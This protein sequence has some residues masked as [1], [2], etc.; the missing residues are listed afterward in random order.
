M[1]QMK[2]VN[3]EKGYLEMSVEL[4]YFGMKRGK[5]MKRSTEMG[6]KMVYFGFENGYT[7]GFRKRAAHSHQILHPLLVKLSLFSL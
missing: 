1:M 3:R 7:K 4:C 6:G 5:F 2:T